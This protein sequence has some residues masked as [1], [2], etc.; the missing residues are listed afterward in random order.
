MFTVSSHHKQY[1][2][3]AKIFIVATSFDDHIKQ[4]SIMSCFKH[5]LY[6]EDAV[7]QNSMYLFGGFGET[8]M[9]E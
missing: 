1:N 4:M 9:N 5:M 3:I 8:V 7:Y 6:Q 2:K